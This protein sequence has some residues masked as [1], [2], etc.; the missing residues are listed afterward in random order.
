MTKLGGGMRYEHEIRVDGVAPVPVAD[1]CQHSH[2]DG[3]NTRRPHQ[4]F[5]R[6]GVHQ[7]KNARGV[8]SHPTVSRA[9]RAFFFLV[10]P[11]TNNCNSEEK[12]NVE[13]E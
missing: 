11:I 10:H 13:C 5:P 3:P 6:S 8:G 12:C 9:T 2:K 4:I 1:A 7:P